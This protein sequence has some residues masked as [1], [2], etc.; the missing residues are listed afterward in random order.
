MVSLSVS[1]DFKTLQMI[2]ERAQVGGGGVENFTKTTS[3]QQMLGFCDNFI[4]KSLVLVLKY[5]ACEFG[6]C[7][8]VFKEIT[9]FWRKKNLLPEN[10]MKR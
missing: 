1:H 2:V 9:I 10:V 5:V 3:N 7:A 4:D 6:G 8:S